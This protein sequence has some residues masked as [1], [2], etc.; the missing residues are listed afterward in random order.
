MMARVWDRSVPVTP[1]DGHHEG[2]HADDSD[3]TEEDQGSVSGCRD[4]V[5]CLFHV[6]K[7]AVTACRSSYWDYA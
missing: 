7:Y 1:Q 5:E 6:S 2:D 4:G 3:D